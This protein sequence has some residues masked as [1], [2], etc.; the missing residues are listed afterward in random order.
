[1]KTHDVGIFVLFKSFICVLF[2]LF[3]C[4]VSDEHY[5]SEEE[6]YQFM[7]RSVIMYAEYLESF[8]NAP[9]IEP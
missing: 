2:S 1:M 8:C 5:E 7:W 3:L 6:L 9:K 4:K